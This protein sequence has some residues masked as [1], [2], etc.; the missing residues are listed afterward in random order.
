VA[1]RSVRI[2]EQ[3]NAVDG[4][5]ENIMS[6]PTMSSGKGIKN[7]YRCEQINPRSDLK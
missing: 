4:Q 1:T 5:P 2:K 6:S 7:N 3:T